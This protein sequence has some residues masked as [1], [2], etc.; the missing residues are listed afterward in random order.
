MQVFNFFKCYSLANIIALRFTRYILHL[1]SRHFSDLPRSKDNVKRAFLQFQ[2]QLKKLGH[3][4]L[5]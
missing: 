4:K 3:A 1:E 5:C 2:I